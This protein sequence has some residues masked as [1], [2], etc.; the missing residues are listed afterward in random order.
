MA[1]WTV[2]AIYCAKYFA[3]YALLAK[4]GVKCE[5]QDCTIVLFGFLFRAAQFH[6]L[7]RELG[8]SKEDRVDV[9]YYSREVKTNLHDIKQQTKQFVVQIEELIDGL[10]LVIPSDL[11][12]EEIRTFVSRIDVCMGLA[13]STPR[14]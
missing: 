1:E 3:V 2:S 9:Q 8:Q 13:S 7:V 5:I 4:I 12:R 11:T 14:P 10:T 6:G